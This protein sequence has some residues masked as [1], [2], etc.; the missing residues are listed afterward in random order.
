MLVDDEAGNVSQ[1]LGAA[2]GRRQEASLKA[3]PVVVQC[4][5]NRLYYLNL[6]SSIHSAVE[7]SLHCFPV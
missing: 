7:P 5:M 1:A 4:V 2:G 3:L 6:Y